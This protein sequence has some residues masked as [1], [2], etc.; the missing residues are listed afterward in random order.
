[1]ASVSLPVIIDIE[2][3]GFGSGSYPIEIG[4]ALSDASS[5]CVLVK[6]QTE[7]THWDREGEALHRISRATLVRFG[8]PA[9]DVAMEL[10]ELLR[11]KTVYSDGWGF[12]YSWLSRLYDS[13]AMAPEFR[14]E[15]LASI[16]SEQQMAR[17]DSVK[18]QIFAE[19]D[20]QRHR[21]SND[22]RVLQ[23]T[24]QRTQPLARPVHTVLHDQ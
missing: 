17:W 11:G 16:L 9:R 18:K 1:M 24:Y 8:K 23:L 6:P 5:R 14:L 10:N 13:V 15:T 22:A 19:L 12:D 4:L 21:A 7:W 2:A 20:F 3:S